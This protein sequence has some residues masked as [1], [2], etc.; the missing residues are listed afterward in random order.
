M[1]FQICLLLLLHSWYYYVSVIITYL[2]LALKKLYLLIS[3]IWNGNKLSAV[4]IYRT[5]NFSG[6][7]VFVWLGCFGGL[8]F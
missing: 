2:Q 8:C 3:W 6:K 7:D 1:R 4:L 5:V